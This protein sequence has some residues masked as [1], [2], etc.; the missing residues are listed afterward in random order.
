MSQ[1]RHS[2][3]TLEVSFSAEIQEKFTPEYLTWGKF[4]ATTVNMDR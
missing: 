4:P 3:F 1:A 2:D